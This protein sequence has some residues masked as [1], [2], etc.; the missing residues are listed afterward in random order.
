[1][2]KVAL[3]RFDLVCLQEEARIA[4]ELKRKERGNVDKEGRPLFSHHDPVVCRK[5]VFKVR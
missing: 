3:W 4:E 5:P 1:M 2:G